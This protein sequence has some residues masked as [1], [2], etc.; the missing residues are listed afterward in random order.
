M[1]A[2]FEVLTEQLTEWREDG[3]LR[4]LLDLAQ[5]SARPAKEFSPTDQPSTPAAD[6][7]DR[8]EMT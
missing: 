3:F 8:G 6:A 4:D 1:Q 5:I 2:L 7:A